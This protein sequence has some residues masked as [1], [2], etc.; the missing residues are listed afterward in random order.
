M[1]TSDNDILRALIHQVTKARPKGLPES[2]VTTIISLP[3]W[4]AFNRSLK[5]HESQS[6]SYTPHNTKTNHTVYGSLTIVVPSDR[7]FSVSYPTKLRP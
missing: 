3:M 6:P 2:F 7:M 5:C 4:K 1:K